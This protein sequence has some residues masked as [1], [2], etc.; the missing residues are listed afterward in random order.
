[1]KRKIVQKKN[2]VIESYF[3]RFSQRMTWVNFPED[4][5]KDMHLIKHLSID[6]EYEESH[7]IIVS[8]D[9]DEEKA[10]EGRQENFK[11]SK[12][13]TFTCN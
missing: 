8:L 10:R 11:I 12:R 1:M 7:P 6:A 9:F 4:Y 13:I 2:S 3:P 5:V